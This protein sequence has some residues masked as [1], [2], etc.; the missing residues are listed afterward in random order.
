MQTQLASSPKDTRQPVRLQISIN[1]K[2]PP[3]LNT[4]YKQLW[5]KVKVLQ[6]AGQKLFEKSQKFKD[7][8]KQKVLELEAR[9][10]AVAERE[11]RQGYTF[12]G[13]SAR[14]NAR[15]D[16]VFDY[17]APGDN[18]DMVFDIRY[19]SLERNH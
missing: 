18:N 4:I 6:I 15:S 11:R 2:G 19:S 10:K 5:E 8:E 3:R 12:T 17:Q 1:K 9:E 14:P 13:Y 7:Y 16:E